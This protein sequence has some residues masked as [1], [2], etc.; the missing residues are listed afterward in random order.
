[1]L[2]LFNALFRL[3]TWGANLKIAKIKLGLRVWCSQ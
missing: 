3:E 2:I 1:M